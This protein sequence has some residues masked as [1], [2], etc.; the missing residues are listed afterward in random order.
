MI[1]G[2]L[3]W[4]RADL[5]ARKAAFSK[6]LEE[7]TLTEEQRAI[8]AER[9]ADVELVLADIETDPLGYMAWVLGENHGVMRRQADRFPQ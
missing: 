7:P 9:L 1:E 2:T 6:M 4:Y 8:W 3:A 5:E